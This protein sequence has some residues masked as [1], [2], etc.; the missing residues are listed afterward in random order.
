[1]AEAPSPAPTKAELPTI[2]IDPSIYEP[3]HPDRP[4]TLY[5]NFIRLTRVTLAVTAVGGATFGV[6]HMLE[7]DSLLPRVQVAS[8]TDAVA[9][10]T[11]EPA[12]LTA[13]PA[14][15]EASAPVRAIPEPPTPTPSVQEIASEHGSAPRL[16]GAELPSTPVPGA[17]P[18][19][20]ETVEAREPAL[21]QKIEARGAVREQNSLALTARAPAPVN[22]QPI[23]ASQARPSVPFLPDKV[24]K[25][26]ASVQGELR[27]ARRLLALNQLEAAEAA[28]RRVLAENEAEQAA[29]TGLARVQLALG[30]LDLALASAKRAVDEAPEAASARLALAD[31]LRARGDKK[32]AQA[33]YDLAAQAAPNR[34]ASAP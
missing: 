25:K 10:L 26:E 19:A 5:D 30:Q 23:E 33:H 12:E 3:E 16:P 14:R 4:Q 24:L 29:L 1:M 13:G 15:A 11:A 7:V 17:Q 27:N 8:L 32:G 2:I 21:E 18:A 31:I 28:Y 34:E 22:A 6:A 20:A 9:R